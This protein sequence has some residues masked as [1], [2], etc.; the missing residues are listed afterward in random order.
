ML[1]VVDQLARDVAQLRALEGRAA[2]LRNRIRERILVELAAGA[3]QQDIVRRTGWT[4]ETIRKI[5]R[6]D[7]PS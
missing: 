1:S 3:T 6:R 5:Q 7:T 4:R 2:Q